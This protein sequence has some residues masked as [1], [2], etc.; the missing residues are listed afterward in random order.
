MQT[1]IARPLRLGAPGPRL[2]AGAGRLRGAAGR[3]VQERRVRRRRRSRARQDLYFQPGGSALR[4]GEAGRLRASSS[5]QLL[6][7][8]TDILIHVGSTGSPVLDARRRGTLKASMPRTPARVRLVRVDSDA[9][10]ATCA[11]T[12]PQVEVV[13]YNRLNIL[14]PGNPAASYELTT[15]LPNQ[16]CSN[17]I[18]LALEADQIRDLTAPRDFHG[19]EGVTSVGAVERHREGKVITTPLGI[20]TEELTPWPSPPPRKAA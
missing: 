18:N 15:P 13:Q 5:T 19:S 8:E 9:R 14:C 10:R 16:G 3:I 11:P 2:G 4:S 1:P 7:P 20:T 17:A 6:T 12:S